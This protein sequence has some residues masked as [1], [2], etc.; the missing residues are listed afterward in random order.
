[1][2]FFNI[3]RIYFIIIK[4]ELLNFQS[5]SNIS[6]YAKKAFLCFCSFFSRK[7]YTIKEYLFKMSIYFVIKNH[8]SMRSFK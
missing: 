1:M 3:F 2:I 5:A 7:I 6:V 4:S 8:L